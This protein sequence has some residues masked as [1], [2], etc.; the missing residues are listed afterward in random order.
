MVV[1]A[2]ARRTSECLCSRSIAWREAGDLVVGFGNGFVGYNSFDLESVTCLRIEITTAREVHLRCR[3]LQR[4][5]AA[6]SFWERIIFFA[7]NACKGA[8]ATSAA[9]ASGH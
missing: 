2:Y 1:L 5:C 3:G 7:A 9:G 4:S 6:S 8:A